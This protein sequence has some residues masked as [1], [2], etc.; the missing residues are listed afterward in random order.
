MGST[1]DYLRRLAEHNNIKYPEAFTSRGI[2]W[3][4]HHLI[5]CQSSEQAYAIESHIKTMR[6]IKY[7]KNLALYPEIIEKLKERFH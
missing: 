6:S 5:K 1:N 4:L 2:P 3:V 7:I